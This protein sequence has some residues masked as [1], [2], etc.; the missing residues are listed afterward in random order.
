[1]A[2]P[3]EPFSVAILAGGFGTRLGRDKAS[4]PAAG[5]PLLHWTAR[6]AAACSDDLIAVRRPDQALPA[7]ADS[8]WR[9]AVD[10]RS[11]RGPLAGL[12]AALAA[13]RHDLVLLVACDMPLLRA[14]AL[15]AVAAAAAGVEL[16][17]PLAGGREQPL[18]AAYRR[19]LL[20]R[21]SG[22][23]DRG[24]GR[25]RALLPL[26]AHRILAE[27]ALRAADP[28]LAT[29]ANVNRPEDLE[30]VGALLAAQSAAAG[31]ARGSG[32]GRPASE[33]EGA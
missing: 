14:A 2:G 6:A 22:L 9:E 12:E 11:G 7:A 27:E 31:A 15:R 30:R 10:G 28:E 17:M 23:L 24:E 33:G 5:R 13:A 1:M 29:L 20:P 4:C 19:G 8:A 16:A 32:T 3:A 21:V 26:A 25:L 18:H